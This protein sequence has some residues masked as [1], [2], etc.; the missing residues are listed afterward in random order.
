MKRVRSP[1]TAPHVKPAILFVWHLPAAVGG[2]ATAEATRAEGMFMEA[3]AARMGRVLVSSTGAPQ[4]TAMVWFDD[5]ARTTTFAAHFHGM[6]HEGQTLHVS[7]RG[8]PGTQCPACVAARAASRVATDAP[9]TAAAAFLAAVASADTARMEA[10][11][12][13]GARFPVTARDDNGDAPLHIAAFKGHETVLRW[14]LKHGAEA[15][16]TS[17]T[18]G[19]VTPLHAAVARGYLGCARALLDAGADPNARDRDGFTPL[20]RAI[21]DGD[22]ECARVLLRCP[23][24]DLANF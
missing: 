17:L 10:T 8:G 3:G 16:V 1:A 24:T 9:A 7:A 6:Q 5:E 19:Y 20:A 12:V 15:N 23:R 11:L 13:A 21:A 4:A 18:S 22:V 14:L 2:F